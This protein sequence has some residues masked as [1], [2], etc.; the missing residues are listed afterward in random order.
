LHKTIQRFDSE[1]NLR[2]SSRY[3]RREDCG[4][5][6]ARTEDGFFWNALLPKNVQAAPKR[7]LMVVAAHDV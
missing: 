5:I 6:G 3:Y 7:C 2:V 1:E 4:D